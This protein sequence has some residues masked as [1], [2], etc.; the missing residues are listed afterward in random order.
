MNTLH[1]INDL[2]MD[3]IQYCINP[4]LNYNDPSINVIEDI[5]GEE[6][7]ISEHKYIEEYYDIETKKLSYKKTYLD[8]ILTIEYFNIQESNIWLKKIT[9]INNFR[10]EEYHDYKDNIQVV[11][12]YVDNK[13]IEKENYINCLIHD[14]IMFNNSGYVNQT[15]KY[16]NGILSTN[17][18]EYK[19]DK[20][21]Y[22]IYTSWYFSGRPHYRYKHKNDK[23]HGL[24]KTWSTKGDIL[25]EHYY[26]NEKFIGHQRT[27]DDKFPNK[28]QKINHDH[29]NKCTVM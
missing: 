27:W 7:K 28:K 4:Y 20:D 1:H 15:N 9:Y 3:V 29:S 26:E 16:N 21:I 24:Q 12:K 23:K 6:L 13:L 5:I 8:N 17:E 22:I 11:L 14:R 25:G 18:I 2:P 10:K 19:D